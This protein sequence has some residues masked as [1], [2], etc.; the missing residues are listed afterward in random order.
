MVTIDEIKS[1]IDELKSHQQDCIYNMLVEFLSNNEVDLLSLLKGEMICRS[2]GSLHLVKNGSSKGHQRYKCKL[3]GTTMSCDANTPLYNLKHKDKWVDYIYYML[4]MDY[5]LSC[6]KISKVIGINKKTAHEWRHKFLA[7]LNRTNPLKATKI[8]EMDE[9]FV[10]F[11][12]KGQIGNEKYEEFYYDGCKYN[13]PSKLRKKERYYAKKKFNNVILCIHNRNNDFD[14]VPMKIQKKGSVATSDI[15][16]AVEYTGINDITVV[17]DCSKS[18]IKY[19]K[20]RPD[21]MHET[22]V[23]DD[24]KKGII[25]DANIHNNN[26]NNT[27]N[28]LRRWMKVF[29][30]FSTKYLWN[31]LKWFRFI[32]LFNAFKMKEFAEYSIEDKYSYKRFRD[33]FN[34][35]N[36]YLYA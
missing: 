18:M 26:I 8:V 23:S 33:L 27:M 15:A 34:I 17:T 32:R 9:V 2:C 19:F 22:F 6:E 7:A 3:C 25:V 1:K 20:T 12:V 4:S 16:K 13:K 5:S 11:C 10:K 31:Y 21:I 28:L 36:K 24:I 29:F 14:F 30:G 35:Y